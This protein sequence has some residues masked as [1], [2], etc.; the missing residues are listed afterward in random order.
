[1][2]LDPKEANK[3]LVDYLSKRKLKWLPPGQT[4]DRRYEEELCVFE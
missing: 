4:I 3:R 2:N 1:M